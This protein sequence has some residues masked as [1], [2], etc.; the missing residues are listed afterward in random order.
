MK[1]T[2]KNQKSPQWRMYESVTQ[3]SMK[4]LIFA[5]SLRKSPHVL[6]DLSD[7]FPSKQTIISCALEA[8]LN[9]VRGKT[10]VI[11]LSTNFLTVNSAANKSHKDIRYSAVVQRPGFVGVFGCRSEDFIGKNSDNCDSSVENKENAPRKSHFS[12]VIFNLFFV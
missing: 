5:V 8:A 6:K 12:A 9:F 10:F 4:C 7:H 2:P 1:V 11:F 3:L